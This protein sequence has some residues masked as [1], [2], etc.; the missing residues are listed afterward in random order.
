MITIGRLN[1]NVL[2]YH[3]LWPGLCCKVMNITFDVAK[4]L[5]I[6]LAIMA[7]SWENI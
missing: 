7:T 6:P 4:L 1:E 3:L 5:F 2:E